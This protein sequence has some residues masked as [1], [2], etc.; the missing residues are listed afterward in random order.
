[1][2]L[3]STTSPYLEPQNDV[4]GVMLNVN[5][6]LLPAIAALLWYFGWGV[7]INIVIA[8]AAALVAEAVMVK[9]RGR[10]ALPAL[11]PRR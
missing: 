6:A 10:P 3:A 7:L 2:H 9:L 8:S 4:T 11:S 5:L 1:M